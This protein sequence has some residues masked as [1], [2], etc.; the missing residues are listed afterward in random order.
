[1]TWKKGI[2]RLNHTTDEIL[3]DSVEEVVIVRPGYFQEMW[4]HAFETI[5]AD[6]PVVYS[7]ITPLDHKIP[8]VNDLPFSP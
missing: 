2:L 3:K 8:M 1:M 7:V 5:K 4:A 6:P